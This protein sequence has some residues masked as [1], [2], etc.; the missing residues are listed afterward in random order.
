LPGKGE[1]VIE[2]PET[3]VH[4]RVPRSL[5]SL[6]DR[7]AGRDEL[8]GAALQAW[9]DFE[10]GCRRAGVSPDLSR[11]ELE[12]AIEG[13]VVEITHE[14]HRGE[15]HATDWPRWGRMG[16]LKVLE[17]YGAAYFGHLARRRWRRIS[18]EDLTRIRERLRRIRRGSA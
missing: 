16:G 6:H 13:S 5:L 17:L 3:E 15:T 11:N 7:M 10:E 2:N 1:A 12:A 8:D 4:H 18:P 14:E 9:F